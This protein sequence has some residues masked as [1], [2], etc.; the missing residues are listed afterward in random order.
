[1]TS[2]QFM[3]TRRDVRHKD[4]RARGVR[5]RLRA[6]GSKAWQYYDARLQRYAAAASRKDAIDRRAKSQLD[7]SAG[8][9]APDT[10]TR[11]KDLAEEVRATKKRRLRSASLGMYEYALDKIILPELGHLKPSAVSPDRIARLIRDLE[12]RGLSP[13][14]IRRYLSPLGAIFKLAIRRGAISVNPLDLLSPDERP[15]GGGVAEHYEW[16]SEEISAL[17]AAAEELDRRPESRYGY[18][19][20]IKL[21]VLTG[22][23]VSEGLALRWQ[24]VDLLSGILHVRHSLNRDGTLGKPKTDAGERE[25]WLSPGLVETLVQLKPLDASEGDFV[26]AS[27]TNRERPVSYHNFRSRGFEPAL[28]KAGLAGKGITIHTLRSAAI[29]LYAARGLTLHETAKVMGQKNPDV[30]WRHYYRLFDKSDLAARVRAA[31]E[32]L[33]MTPS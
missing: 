28:V 7:K 8:L 1:V 9:P 12:T 19:P 11:I 15:S 16:E 33:G 21:L 30:T 31:Q 6:D 5:Y 10:R 14:T 25:V 17:I 26:F 29:S 2:P 23:R 24:D 22:L 20:L 3:A 32:S 27:K 13:A 4:G 18:A